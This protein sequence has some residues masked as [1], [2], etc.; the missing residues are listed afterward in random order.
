MQLECPTSAL[1]VRRVIQRVPFA[2]AEVDD[3]FVAGDD[4]ADGRVVADHAGMTER[5]L[6]HLAHLPL[7]LPLFTTTSAKRAK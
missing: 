1:A 6:G 2:V 5:S 3:L 4:R 7:G